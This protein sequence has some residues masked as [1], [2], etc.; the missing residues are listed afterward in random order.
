MADEPETHFVIASPVLSNP[1][2]VFRG[3]GRPMVTIKFDPPH[4]EIDTSHDWSGAAKLFWN[5]VAKLAG[6]PPPFGW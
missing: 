6:Q 4:V 3:N 5:E 2:F 1:C